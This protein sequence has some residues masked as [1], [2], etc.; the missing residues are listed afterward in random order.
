MA[1]AHCRRLLWHLVRRDASR[2]AC[3]AG[4]SSET[5]TPMMAITTSSSTSVKPNLG[6]RRGRG[7]YGI[8]EL[9]ERNEIGNRKGRTTRGR[10]RSRQAYRSI[11]KAKPI[12]GQPKAH[13]S[14]TRAMLL[15]G[16]F[17]RKPLRRCVRPSGNERRSDGGFSRGFE[18]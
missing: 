8:G 13:E 18:N 10:S 12:V 14:S 11:Y 1:S 6:R 7:A 2:A 3:T 15:L 4:K 17:L 5:S 16:S 9:Q